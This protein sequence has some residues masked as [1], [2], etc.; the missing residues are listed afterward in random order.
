MA[1]GLYPMAPV[2]KDELRPEA[3][4][5]D[6]KISVPL[7]R[8]AKLFPTEKTLHT[9]K[10]KNPFQIM[11]VTILR[12]ICERL[13]QQQFRNGLCERYGE[14]YLVASCSLL[15]VLEAAHS[16]LPARGEPLFPA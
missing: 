3:A 15:V 12:E 1:D 14:R 16:R 4:N 6:G 11:V 10:R 2:N 7:C 5:P 8:V 9:T 13:G